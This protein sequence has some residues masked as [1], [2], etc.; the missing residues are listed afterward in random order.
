MSHCNKGEGL[1]SSDLVAAYKRP[2]SDAAGDAD[3]LDL[4]QVQAALPALKSRNE[5][6]VCVEPFGELFLL[7]IGL[8]PN[9]AQQI[10]QG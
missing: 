2:K 6:L 9:L 7:Q 4:D 3:L 10:L 5:A 1:L 8:K